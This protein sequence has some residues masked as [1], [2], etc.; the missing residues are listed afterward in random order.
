[1]RTETRRQGVAARS[2]AATD[3]LQRIC[4]RLSAQR[5]LE[6]G[7]RRAR[8]R[9]RAARQHAAAGR[10]EPLLLLLLCGLRAAAR[11]V[12]ARGPQTL[13]WPSHRRCTRTA[14][15]AC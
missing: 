8:G 4:A 6:L 9:V 5:A 15:S 7:R 13:H 1:M 2:V 14:G 3:L 10:Q 12:L 11:R